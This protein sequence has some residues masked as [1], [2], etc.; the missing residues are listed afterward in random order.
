MSM[1]PQYGAGR[2]VTFRGRL[3]KG[4]MLTVALLAVPLMALWTNAAQAQDQDHIVLGV[5]VAAT[6]AYQGAEDYRVIPLPAIDIKKGWL[7]ANLR[8]GI[9]IEPISTDIVTIGASAVFVQGY[10]K[11]DMPD[12]IDKLSDGVGA[13]LFANIRAGGFVATIGAVKTVSGG[14]KGMV[15][16]ASLSYPLRVSPRFTLTPTIGTTW[17]D[18]KYN[19]R[20]FGISAAEALASGLPQF[21]AGSGFK[22]VSGALTASYRLTDRISVSATGSVSSLLG[23]VKDSPIVEKK[24]QPS[25]IL[26]LTYRL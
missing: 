9:G 4:D 23:E 5:G 12:G 8:N 24:T 14:T 17:A 6:P 20:Y 22:D 19:D 26:T 1:F 25:G 2:G 16:D 15:A 3:V 7:F 13:R 21:T 18:R 10:R 11:K